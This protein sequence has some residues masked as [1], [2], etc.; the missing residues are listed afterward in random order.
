MRVLVTG[1]NGLLGHHVVF[2]LLED[3]YDVSVILRNSRNIHF[4]M[5]RVRV[6]D[7]SFTDYDKLKAFASDCDAIIHVA[8]VTSTDL[9]HYDE[10]KEIN[11]DASATV[12]QIANELNINRIVYV[13]T[14]NTIGYGSKK[15][16][17]DEQ[18][19]IC[20]PFTHSFYAKSKAEAEKLFQDA[21]LLPDRHVIIINPTF[22][23]GGYDIKPSSGKLLLMGYKKRFL[24]IPRGGKNF[25]S[26]RSVAKA[27]A[28]ALT[29]GKNGERYLASGEN[30]SF[31]RFYKLQR[32]VGGYRQFIFVIPDFVVKV[33]GYFGDFM[34]AGGI[35]TDVCSM[36]IRQLL[37]RE[38]YCNHK[39]KNELDL[40]P[41]RL[42][43]AIRESI[44]WFK[45]TGK[46][47]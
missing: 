31:R 46:I 9:L 45:S 8:A 38:N 2:Q 29:M 43:D 27:V 3:G 21:S 42:A 28:N 23:I 26:V 44:E 19:D 37:I 35:Q 14:A 10:Y 47:E 22:M 36:N 15:A 1:A 20:Y 34:R 16:C 11:V 41:T 12:I 5:N 30:M 4:D 39:A 6:C 33:V 25:V 13:S 40:P 24:V 7:G 32:E 17:A 18:C